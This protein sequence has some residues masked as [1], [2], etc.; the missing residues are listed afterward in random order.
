MDEEGGKFVNTIAHMIIK[1]LL[2]PE[3]INDKMCFDL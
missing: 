3:I 1:L 2:T